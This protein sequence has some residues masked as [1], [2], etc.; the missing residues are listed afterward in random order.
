MEFER[1]G[2]LRDALA[3]LDALEARQKVVDVEGADRDVV[4]LA[5]DG[6]E[7]CG[8]VLRIRE[9][10]LLGREAIF[11][12]NLADDPDEEVLGVFAARFYASRAA[13]DVGGTPPEI[14]FPAEFDDRP[15]LEA[16]LRERAARAVHTHVPQRGEKARLIELAEQNARHLLE[17]RR[18]IAAVATQRAPDA[19]YELQEALELESV[20]R[21]IVC[22]DISHTQGSEVVASASFF[23]NGAPKKAEY[24][25]F[26]IRGA[27]GN[28]D[29]RSMHEV[30]TRYFQRRLDEQ[31]PLPDLAVIDGGKGQLSAAREAL[32]ALDLAQQPVVSL[33]KREEEIFIP[34]QA[35]PIRLPRRSPA[36][37]LLQRIRDEAHRFAI[38]Y[39]RKLRTKRT[40][41]SELSEIPGVGPARQR[42][43]LERFGSLRAVAGASVEQIAALPG[44]GT[45]LAQAVLEHA[46]AVTGA[47]A[48]APQGTKPAERAG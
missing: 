30:V 20:P 4:G 6:D 22:F 11:L 43:L 44:F 13:E 32:E 45:A 5:R 16:L 27:W 34:G 36:L 42:A 3:E 15:V 9:G 2:E 1:A 26:K 24:R 47:A 41:R 29:F 31:K 35:A 37:K 48:A 25:K 10:K 12:S 38:G 21:T 23:E 28:D 46:R 17:E 33:A 14:L 18:L 19:L 8:V 7:A 39:N 40:I